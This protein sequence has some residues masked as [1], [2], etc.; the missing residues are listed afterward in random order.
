MRRFLG[1]LVLLGLAGTLGFFVLTIPRGLPAA[2][3]ATLPEGDAAR[4]ETWFW[5]GG[6]GS[7]HAPERARGDDKFL[8]GGGLELVTEF[9]TFVAPNISPHPEDGIG[10]WNA[11][12]FANAMKRGISPEGRH[13]YPAFPY[14]SYTRM[15]LADIA[16][17]WAFLQTL[18]PV[19]GRAADSALNFP[20]NIRRG[21]GLWKLAFLDDAPV[22]AV[23][24]ADPVLVRGRY[25]VEG[26]GHCA[27]C[28]SPRNFGGAVDTALWLAGA[29]AAD[30]PGRIPNIT[31]GEGGI[32]SWSPGDLTY[33]FETGFTPDFDSV[34]G[35][36][37]SVQDNLSRLDA[38]DRA[39]IAA[40]LGAVPPHASAA[41]TAP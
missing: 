38:A 19:E 17:L 14:A 37:V 18:P 31:P 1:V 23:D 4:G 32:G 12:E 9:G 22:V 27:E 28:H 34:G 41:P 6:C 16:D 15:E 30:G 39:A 33:Y 10:G 35:S 36:M 21:L 25:L 7:C 8:L 26:A 3:L 13:Y 40:Y 5:A 24:P 11:A 2:E 29:P 20:Y